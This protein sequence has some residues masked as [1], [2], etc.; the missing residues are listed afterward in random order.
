VRPFH[1]RKFVSKAQ[2]E[3]KKVLHTI[4]NGRKLCKI[5]LENKFF[6]VLVGQENLRKMELLENNK[7]AKSNRLLW[8]AI[9]C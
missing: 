3:K 9:F 5:T 7:L 4:F 2:N 6:H 8:L 1:L